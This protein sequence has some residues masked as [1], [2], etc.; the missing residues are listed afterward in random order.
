[1]YRGNLRDG[2]TVAIKKMNTQGGPDAEH[3]F[4]TEVV[5]KLINICLFVVLKNAFTFSINWYFHDEMPLN[6][7]FI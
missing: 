2:R 5:L 4:L 6:I 3:L 1:M 7:V